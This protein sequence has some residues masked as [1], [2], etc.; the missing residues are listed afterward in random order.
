MAYTEELSYEKDGSSPLGA[1]NLTAVTMD[2]IDAMFA[3]YMVSHPIPTPTLGELLNVADLV[4]SAALGSIL[5][6]TG[7]GWTSAL[8]ASLQSIA[9]TTVLG[10]V[11]VGNGLLVAPDGTISWDSTAAYE[12]PIASDVALG[13]IM[14]GAGLAIDVD[15]V[16]TT[17]WTTNVDDILD[18][19]GTKY[20]A[21]SAKKSVDP[22]YA[23]FYT[24]ASYPTF[25]NELILD[26]YLKASNV[27]AA[28]SS[29]IGVTLASTG[30]IT[31]LSGANTA[32]YDISAA[33]LEITSYTA[34]QSTPI[35]IG[36]TLSTAG[37]KGQ[38]VKADDFL[39][40]LTFNFS[41]INL[42]QGTALKW[43]ALDASNNISYQDAPGAAYV[44]HTQSALAPT[45]TG[46]SVLAGLLVDTEGHTTGATVRALLL[47][48]IGFTGDGNA[49]YYEHPLSTLPA[50]AYKSFSTDSYGHL[51]ANDDTLVVHT[52]DN[53]TING[54]K[55]FVDITTLG[56]INIPLIALPGD[57]LYIDAGNNVAYGPGPQDTQTF[58]LKMPNAGSVG[59]RV[60]LMTE[61]VHYPTGWVI[62]AYLGNPNHLQIVH[63]IGKHIANVTVFSTTG[64]AGTTPERQLLSSA[65]YTGIVA[66]DT[67]TLIIEGLATYMSELYVHITL[68]NKSNA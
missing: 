28:A 57:Y 2:Q 46:A 19:T 37:R 22:A 63:G 60:A 26:G 42:A 59:A 27:T 6:S 51:I 44:H 49:N 41:K 7:S 61:G 50:N 68:T 24:G 11:I 1:Y 8:S 29:T 20:A 67:N 16:L 3:A 13:G 15:G 36:T 32:I 17:T 65:A 23:Y 25:T 55:T 54:N 10:S 5:V 4:D 30:D 43:L 31:Q 58:T 53:E 45:L 62:S 9:T 64:F 33:G 40:T 14:V 52:I 47:S 18:W 34:S 39:D 48:D 35:Y 12:L 66:E 38:Y 21:Y 56:V